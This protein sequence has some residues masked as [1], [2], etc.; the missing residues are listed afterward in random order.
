MAALGTWRHF[1]ARFLSVEMITANAVKSNF[2][3]FGVVETTISAVIINP[4]KPKHAEDQQAV[5]NNIER[6]IRGGDHDGKF[7]RTG[8]DAKGK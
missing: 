7:T 4:Q 5:E 6:K 1:N 2:A 8:R 3:A